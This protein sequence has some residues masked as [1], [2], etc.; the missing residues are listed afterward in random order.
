ML[1]SERRML[2]LALALGAA[3]LFSSC[4]LIYWTS[5]DI[6]M[7]QTWLDPRPK[8]ELPTVEVFIKPWI[9]LFSHSP[10][11]EKQ[12]EQVGGGVGGNFSHQVVQRFGDVLPFLQEQTELLPATRKKLVQILADPL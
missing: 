10:K 3:G 6:H 12:V 8:F 11:E 7:P 2:L 1:A 5:P 4:S 9:G